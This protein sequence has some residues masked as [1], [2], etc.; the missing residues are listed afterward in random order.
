MLEE[1]KAPET[2][3]KPEVSADEL[4]IDNRR[5]EVETQVIAEN[6]VFTPEVQEEVDSS[7][8]KEE[9]SEDPL[10]RIK[11]SVQKRI[12]K[13]VAKQKSAEEK[14]AE[15]EA[16]IARLK[17]YQATE[18]SAEVKPDQELSSIQIKNW[19]IQRSKEGLLT[20]EEQTE[21]IILLA[22]AKEREAIK[23][24]EDKQNKVKQEA[25]AKV[26][27]ENAALVD[28]ARDYV[29]LNDKGEADMKSDLT[30]SN[31][32]GLLFRTTMAL[33]NDPELHRDF[34]NDPDRPSALRRAVSDAYREIHQQGLIKTPKV[35]GIGGPVRR[36]VLADPET[37]EV[38]E[39]PTQTNSNPLSDAEK[40]RE[41]IRQRNKIRNTRK[42]S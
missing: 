20:S 1:V 23:S 25:E 22:D 12:D 2:P 11:K 8:P 13:V 33:Y 40:V 16:E 41:E 39:T 15:A 9:V 7:K 37:V 38:E 10:E 31:Q 28:L 42:V 21:A 17:S 34:Y 35:D 14:L 5:L 4:I 19:M 3:V 24:V 18:V 30:L 26:T 36:Q 6:D 27:R 29:I 32:K